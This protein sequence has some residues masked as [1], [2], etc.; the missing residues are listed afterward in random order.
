[1]ENK[2]GLG[3]IS[4]FEFKYIPELNTTRTEMGESGQTGVRQP[5]IERRNLNSLLTGLG[6]MALTSFCCFKIISG[7]VHKVAL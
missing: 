5:G 7:F 2:H 1:M 4:A 6:M 3:E